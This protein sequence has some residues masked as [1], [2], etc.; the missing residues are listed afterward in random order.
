MNSI[1]EGSF[2]DILLVDPPRQGLDNEVCRMAMMDMNETAA[3]GASTN[4]GNEDHSVDHEIDLHGSGCFQNILYVSCGHQALLRDLERLSSAYKVI[5]CVQMDLF[6]R[7]DSIETLVHL[8]K[9]E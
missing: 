2:Y 5:N 1:D 6:P 7:T 3:V 4:E 9:R 8:R